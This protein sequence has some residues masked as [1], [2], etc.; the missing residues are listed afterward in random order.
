MTTLV[1]R[2]NTWLNGRRI[3]QDAAG[4]VYY[5]DKRRRHGAPSRRWV[6]YAAQDEASAVPPEWHAWLHYTTDKPIETTTRPWI[7]PHLANATGTP[8]SYRPQGHDYMGGTR[9]AA[10]GDY[11]A[12]TPEEAS[13][14]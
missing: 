2:L 11:E 13:G 14:T 7:K 1:T 4:N 8:A 3:G 5:E 12:W 9:A 10:T 6:I